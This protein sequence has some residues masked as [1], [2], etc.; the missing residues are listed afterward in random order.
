MK[1]AQEGGLHKARCDPFPS[2]VTPRRGIPLWSWVS[3]ARAGTS[4]RS[5]GGTSMA[6]AQGLGPCGFALGGRMGRGLTG[7][8]GAKAEGSCGWD[9]RR[10][11]S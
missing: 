7:S 11:A 5:G 8:E 9:F 2:G 6:E 10:E 3:R 4:L 1:C